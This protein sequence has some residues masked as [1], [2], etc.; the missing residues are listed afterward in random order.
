MCRFPYLG[1]QMR[2]DL[3]D[4]SGLLGPTSR[5]ARGRGLHVIALEPDAELAR[6]ADGADLVATFRVNHCACDWGTS[7]YEALA[8]LTSDLL[9]AK[10]VRRVRVGIWWADRGPVGGGPDGA[11]RM[12]EIDT[13]E[14]AGVDWA[15][16]IALEVRR[17]A[18][19]PYATTILRKLANGLE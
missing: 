16:D 2:S 8:A 1:V 4:R 12:R 15:H 18:H 13:D 3:W 17:A 11:L 6:F 14:L 7:Q 5:I 9:L 10:D 19:P